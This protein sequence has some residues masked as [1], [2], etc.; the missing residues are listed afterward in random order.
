MIAI[1]LGIAAAFSAIAWMLSEAFKSS[2]LKA[3][4]KRELNEFFF[5]AILVVSLVLIIAFADVI[6]T[7]LVGDKFI[8]VENEPAYFTTARNHLSEMHNLLYTTGYD[9]TY[10]AAFYAVMSK[11]RVDVGQIIGYMLTPISGGLSA[12]IAKILTQ[13]VGITITP[14][15][16]LSN[17]TGVLGDMIKF[18]FTVFMFVVGQM[19]LLDFIEKTMLTII[20]PLAV[21]FRAFPLTRKTGSTLIALV[22]VAYFVYPVSVNIGSV[23]YDKISYLMPKNINIQKVV[24][25]GGNI[26]AVEMPPMISTSEAKAKSATWALYGNGTYRLWY[27]LDRNCPSK[28]LS[29]TEPVISGKTWGCACIIKES[30]MFCD[31]CTEGTPSWYSGGEKRIQQP[32]FNPANLGEFS[33]WVI[34]Y[35]SGTSGAESDTTCYTLWGNGTYKGS[36]T[37]FKKPLTSLITNDPSTNTNNRENSL[38]VDIYSKSG[39]ATPTYAAAGLDMITVFIGDPATSEWTAAEERMGKIQEM[40]KVSTTVS[41]GNFFSAMFKALNNLGSELSSVQGAYTPLVLVS[42]PPSFA[43]AVYLSITDRL[44]RIMIPTV[45]VLFTFVISLILTITAFRGISPAIGGESEIAGL[46]KLV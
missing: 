29:L 7:A 32:P 46:S 35:T 5:T 33:K 9:L 40:S 27:S 15:D 1:A 25:V 31:T 19:T 37:Y 10:E 39:T 20:L 28:E 21:V 42:N 16:P 43:A 22:L 8:P 13:F 12:V 18:V 36:L 2:E 17:A 44:P 6:A 23:I 41:Y 34:K 3:W 11:I 4:A 26:T 38:I 14:F 24:D 30:G 45:V